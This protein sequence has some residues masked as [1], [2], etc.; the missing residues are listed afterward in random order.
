MDDDHDH[1]HD[2]DGVDEPLTC[3]RRFLAKERGHKRLDFE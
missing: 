1:D 3:G 2:D